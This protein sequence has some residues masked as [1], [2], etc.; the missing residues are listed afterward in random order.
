MVLLAAIDIKNGFS[1]ASWNNMVKPLREIYHVPP[2]LLR[3]VED[4][5]RDRQLIYETKD[6]PKSKKVTE[7]S[8]LGP[9]LRNI[10]YDDI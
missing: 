2:Y 10:S 5:I 6:C 8:I 7:G 1:S 4:Y 9:E 3:M